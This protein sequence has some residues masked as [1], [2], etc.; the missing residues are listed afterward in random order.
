MPTYHHY[1]NRHPYRH[2]HH[3]HHHAHPHRH[4]HP[5]CPHDNYHVNV[6]KL[7]RD[8]V[9][10]WVTLGTRGSPPPYKQALSTRMG[11]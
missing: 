6:V 8:Y 5:A 11:F 7:K 1:H 2:R 10:R 4:P 3:Y 9:G